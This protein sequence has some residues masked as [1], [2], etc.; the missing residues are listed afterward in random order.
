LIIVLIVLVVVLVVGPGIW[1]SAILKRYSA[2][3]DDIRGNGAEFAQH[4][5][6]KFSM[7][8]VTVEQTPSGDHYDPVSCSVRLSPDNMQTKSLTAVVVAAHEVGHAMQHATGYRPF[9]WRNR[10]VQWSQHA[11][12]LGS[13][14]MLAIPVVT[15]FSRSPLAGGIVTL[16]GLSTLFT[17]VLVHLVTLPV[18]WNASFS[19]ALPV[20]KAGAYL[21]EKD[22]LKARKILLA[23]ALTYLA[24]SLMSLLNVWRW[25]RVL[26]R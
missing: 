17:V 10:L 25:L 20:L 22:L 12:K 8:Y 14:I 6:E 26:K 3:R 9:H 18:E 23:C 2:A 7:P 21:D 13:V 15:L 24:Q 5:T 4:L 1:A 11:E 19:R 16:L